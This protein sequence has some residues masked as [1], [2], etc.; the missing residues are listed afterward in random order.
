MFMKNPKQFHLD[1]NFMAVSVWYV[2]A[3]FIWHLNV[4]VKAQL[5]NKFLFTFTGCWTGTSWQCS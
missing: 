4:F 5:L 1:R 3:V 2:M